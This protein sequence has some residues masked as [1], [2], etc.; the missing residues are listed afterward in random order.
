M[1]NHQVRNAERV[2][3]DS[4]HS[5]ANNYARWNAHLPTNFATSSEYQLAASKGDAAPRLT[6]IDGFFILHFS[7]SLPQPRSVSLGRK[8]RLYWRFMCKSQIWIHSADACLGALPALRPLAA[9]TSAAEAYA[10]LN[11]GSLFD[12]EITSFSVSTS[13]FCG[14]Q[15]RLDLQSR[16]QQ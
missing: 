10:L 8:K 7:F 11:V 15:T 2:I 12:N 9:W 5:P 3:C 1:R 6:P 16:Q 13:D 4:S 14:Q